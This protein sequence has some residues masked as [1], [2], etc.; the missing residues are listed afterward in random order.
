MSRGYK[1]SA[2][3]TKEILITLAKVGIFTIGATSPYFLTSLIKY[4][5]RNKIRERARR[6]KELERKKLVEFKYLPNHE[7]RVVLSH[8]GKKL[9]RQ[10]DLD[11][12]KISK[13]KSWDKKWRIILYDIPQHRKKAS[14]ILAKKFHDLGLYQLQ[15]SVWVS[16]YD[17]LAELEFICAVFEL[18]INHSFF[19][20]TI[21]ELPRCE[22]I[23]KFFNLS[24]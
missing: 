4:Y 22:K 20:L 18:D 17:C 6:L 23:K 1:K 24:I 3:L 21:H 8:Q 7:I 19:Y 16:P 11:N 2:N 5:F 14:V 13:T 12:L 9:V 10:Y 15:K